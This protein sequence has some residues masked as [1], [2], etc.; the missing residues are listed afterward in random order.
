[1]TFVFGLDSKVSKL[2]ALLGYG[3]TARQPSPS[4]AA[5]ESESSY[6]HCQLCQRDGKPISSW[7][8]NGTGTLFKDVAVLAA[9]GAAPAV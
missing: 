6:R 9:A 2:E 1:M 8:V 7:T 5:A 3:K 4:Q